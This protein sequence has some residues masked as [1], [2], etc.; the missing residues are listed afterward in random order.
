MAANAL[1]ISNPQAN[2]RA[3]PDG[4]VS[5]IVGRYMPLV[6]V[7][8]K[9]PWIQ[10]KDFEGE[11]HWVHARMVTSKMNCVVVRSK[12]ANLKSGP[13]ANFGPTELGKVKKYA[14]FKKLGRDD[15]WLKLQDEFGYVHW[16]HEN[17]VWEPRN[18]KR[19]SF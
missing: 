11:K 15:E 13:G 18:Y 12:V 17:T 4:K 9:G 14:T 1:C 5:W 10:V 3:K 2:L 16:V 19:V 6:E 7:S 8:R